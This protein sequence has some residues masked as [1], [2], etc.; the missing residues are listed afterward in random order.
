MTSFLD[1]FVIASARFEAAR[2]VDTPGV[3]PENHQC[4]RLH[5]LGGVHNLRRQNAH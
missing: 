4:K 5:G 2:S 3:L 1:H